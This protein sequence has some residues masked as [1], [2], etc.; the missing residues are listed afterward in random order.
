M[1]I[2]FAFPM[3]VVVLLTL[4]G[5]DR[6]EEITAPTVR[7]NADTASDTLRRGPGSFGGGA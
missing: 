3:L 5:C 4:S 1:R 2:R 6:H 7:P